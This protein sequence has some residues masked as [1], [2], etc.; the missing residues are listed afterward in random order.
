MTKEAGKATADGKVPERQ[1]RQEATAIQ[2]RATED[3]RGELGSLSR[4]WEP[5]E[6]N[7]WDA[8]AMEFAGSSKDSVN[9]RQREGKRNVPASPFFLPSFSLQCLSLTKPKRSSLAGEPGKATSMGRHPLISLWARKGGNRLWGCTGSNP[10]LKMLK[11]SLGKGEVDLFYI[12]LTRW[13][14]QEEEEGDIWNK[15]ENQSPLDVEFLDE[16]VEQCST[17]GAGCSVRSF[18][19]LGHS[20][21]GVAPWKAHHPGPQL[22]HS[23]PRPQRKWLL[24]Q[25]T[26][27]LRRVT[28][29]F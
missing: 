1:V 2:R 21:Q 5:Q 26:N 18:L 8:G 28:S 17:R 4:G 16:M 23:G 13:Q 22:V 11:L 12:F 29:V 24:N 27:W 6:V 19:S 3:L 14:I 25:V 15:P 20:H 10:I 7:G 9:S